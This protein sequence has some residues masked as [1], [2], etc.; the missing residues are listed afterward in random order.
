MSLRLPNNARPAN[1][2]HRSKLMI[3]LVMG[4]TGE[5]SDWRTWAV[6]YL[7]TEEEAEAVVQE[8]TTLYVEYKL[9]I[10]PVYSHDVWRKAWSEHDPEAKEEVAKY[11]NAVAKYKEHWLIRLPNSSQWDIYAGDITYHWEKVSLLTT[12]KVEGQL[13]P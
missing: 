9:G 6:G 7:T 13:I 10:P 5:Y 12:T 4:E 3:Y 8:L 1:S 11:Q 2:V